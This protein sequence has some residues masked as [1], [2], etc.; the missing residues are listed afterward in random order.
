MDLIRLKQLVQ[1][2]ESETVEFKKSTAQLRRAME[3]LC[4]MLNRN[5]GRVL[6][7]VTA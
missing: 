6:I 3:T 7:G 1:R 2:G 4:G 5:G